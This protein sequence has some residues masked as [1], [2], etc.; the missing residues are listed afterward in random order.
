MSMG[1]LTST[2]RAF[3]EA[4]MSVTNI[5]NLRY[6]DNADYSHVRMRKSKIQLILLSA[7][8]CGIE[9]CY[10]AETAFVSPCLLKLGIHVSYMTMV[11]CLS[12]LFGFFMGPLL[13]TLSDRCRLKL[14]RRRPF[15]LILSAGIV[16]GLILVPNGRDLGFLMGDTHA[17]WN[18]DSAE[19]TTQFPDQNHANTSEITPET[20]TGKYYRGPDMERSRFIEQHINGLIIT[21]IGVVFLDFSCDACQ[22]PCRSYLLE[23]TTEQDHATGLTIFTMVAGLGGSIGYL[24][25]GINWNAVGDSNG[26]FFEH[27]RIVFSIV[28][29]L[30]IM[31]VLIT[32]TRFREIPLDEIHDWSLKTSKSATEQD[33]KK[34]GDA[35]E[36]E[37]PAALYDD[38]FNYNPSSAHTADAQ[39]LYNFNS[40]PPPNRQN[41]QNPFPAYPSFEISRRAS[42]PGEGRLSRPYSSP[43]LENHLQIPN[44]VDQDGSHVM[45][46]DEVTLKGYWLSILHMPRS[47]AYLCL[48][49]LFCWMSLVCY[50][51]YFTD[52]VGQ[53]VYGGDPNAP[54]DSKK[55]S[56]YD[57]G[58]R[59]GSFGMALYS[60]S[61]SMY[62]LAIEKLVK[63][64]RTKPVY[65]CGQLVY[66]VGMILMAATKSKVAVILLS[67]TAGIMY[68]TLF[69]LPY[70]LIANYHSCEMFEELVPESTKTIHPRGLGTDVALVS[71]MCFAAQFLLSAGLGS[72]VHAVGSPVAVVVCAA[73]F[74]LFGSLTATKVL[75]LDK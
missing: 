62:S 29:F 5:D 13:G 64:F 37:T 22:A 17:S 24:M 38:A 12:P 6:A 67:P 32:I 70:M 1:L 7:A 73:V 3:K 8:V 19:N 11:W 57:E 71:S 53:V 59:M 34:T 52:F 26:D 60:F 30:F 35:G 46:Q 72:L 20:Y 33:N 69:T 9:F 74:S 42:D 31:C 40:D 56:L 75:Y 27:V 48:T 10:A 18:I 44:C 15:I 68:A 54:A 63:K 61:C 21:I 47:V 66:T 50:S 45:R 14:G 2:M 58:V 16:L 55:H 39:H 43:D 23:V 51:L 41:H 28:L 25:G 65:I 36:P 4:G 49:N